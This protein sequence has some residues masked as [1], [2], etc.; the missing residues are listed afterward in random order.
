MTAFTD[1]NTELLNMQIIYPVVNKTQQQLF[2]T[3]LFCSYLLLLP[4]GY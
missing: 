3:T 4:A 1:S 2:S